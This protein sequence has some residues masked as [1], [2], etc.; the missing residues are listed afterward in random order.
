MRVP[1]RQ[2]ADLELTKSIL[3]PSPLANQPVTFLIDLVNRGPA[4]A[5]AVA[6]REDLPAGLTFVSANPAK[7]SYDNTTGVWTIGTM[8]R[9]E[10][11]T[12]QLTA[13]WNGAA[14]SNVAQV[15]AS[16]TED[17]DSTPNNDIATEDDQD[18]ATLPQQLADLRL[19]KVVSA[20]TVPVGGSAVFTITLTNDGPA[21]ATNV[22]VRERLPAG[23]QYVGSTASQGN[24]DPALGDWA[25]GTLA[26]NQSVTLA[27]EV[28]LLDIGPFANTAQVSAS[29]QED[30]DSTP[31]NDN[32]NEDDQ[33]SA[34]I[35]GEQSDLAISK[36]AS[37]AQPTLGQTLIYTVEVRNDGPSTAN[38]IE[39]VDRL[40]AG[41]TFVSATPSQGTY[42]NTTGLWVVG[43]LTNGARASLVVTAVVAQRG[44]LENEAEVTKSDKPDPDSRPGNRVPSEDDIARVRLPATVI[45]LEL[46]KEILGGGAAV[47]AV[48]DLLTYQI[49]VDN[50]SDPAA[51]ATGVQ[52][53]DRLPQ[54]LVFSAARPERGS[55]NP[56]T[57]A[58][59]IGNIARARASASR[60]TRSFAARAVL[61]TVPRSARPTRWTSTRRRTTVSGVAKMTKIAQR[62][63][64]RQ[65]G[66]GAAL[67]QYARAALWWGAGR[68]APNSIARASICTAAAMAIVAVRSGG[69]VAGSRRRARVVPGR[70]TAGA[71]GA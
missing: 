4:E 62:G 46:Q 36:R 1:V 41:L 59:E 66:R 54:G 70:A 27:L 67:A 22:V 8:A 48:G 40:P 30:P 58:W 63:R 31:N 51:D 68:P 71:I 12:L 26:V 32:P 14:L 6:V 44:L 69:Q 53:T 64:C 65:R 49:T 16:G 18:S 20:P 37:L 28:T 57:G 15:S 43:T 33:S 5:T 34:T 17:I 38:G 3:T 2:I 11:T 39:V 52:V 56:L 25:V 23:L 60:S 13:T 21:T 42:N 7:G 47:P 61:S 29:D 50:V 45:D 10:R 35:N 55:Y 9:D 19:Q 24:Y